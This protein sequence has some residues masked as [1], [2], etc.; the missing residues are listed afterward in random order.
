LTSPTKDLLVKK[1]RKR[2]IEKKSKEKNRGKREIRNY[3]DP[4]GSKFKPCLE[5]ND[6][7]DL[8]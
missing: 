3:K 6:D 7:N 4:M 5:H 2:K 1:K 8:D